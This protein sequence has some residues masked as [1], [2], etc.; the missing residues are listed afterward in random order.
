MNYVLQDAK[1]F[2]CRQSMDLAG[3]IAHKYGASLGKVN[4][5]TFSDGEFQPSLEES[6]RGRRV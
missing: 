4:F 2:G 3:A 1:L 6:I 5:S